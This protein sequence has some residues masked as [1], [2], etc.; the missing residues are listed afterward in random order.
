V[1]FNFP[2][3]PTTALFAEGRYALGLADQDS[4][5]IAGLSEKWTDIQVLVGLR[6]GLG[7]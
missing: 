7:K 5:A 2:L 6:F 4:P 3:A 1:G